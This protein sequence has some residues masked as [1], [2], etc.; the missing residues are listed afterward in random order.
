MK[1][2]IKNTRKSKLIFDINTSWYEIINIIIHKRWNLIKRN[3]T[4]N[5]IKLKVYYY[6]YFNHVTKIILSLFFFLSFSFKIL[7]ILFVKKKKFK[8]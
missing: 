5:T 4:M 6:F 7:F 8:K 2:Y 3:V 1:Y